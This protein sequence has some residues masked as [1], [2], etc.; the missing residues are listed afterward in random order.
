MTLQS[1]KSHTQ[2]NMFAIKSDIYN[3]VGCTE[4]TSK[5]LYLKHTLQNEYRVHSCQ[6]FYVQEWYEVTFML[7]V[8]VVN[9][10]YYRIVF[11]CKN[12][13]DV[14][15]FL[16]GL[17]AWKSEF[18]FLRKFPNWKGPWHYTVQY[19]QPR[20]LFF[21][22]LEGKTSFCILSGNLG[23]ILM[24]SIDR[25]E[26]QTR[27]CGSFFSFLFTQL[28]ELKEKRSGLHHIAPHPG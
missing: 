19:L 25:Y 23:G 27:H 11:Y 24:G 13:R 14:W 18:N 6:G 4:N 26:P 28:V 8:H 7:S 12:R 21:S 5:H 22:Y 17:S 1:A 2:K 16:P 15:F 3:T 10:V 9:E 20:C